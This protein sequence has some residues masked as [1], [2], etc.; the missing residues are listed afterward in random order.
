MDEY[1]GLLSVH[2]VGGSEGGVEQEAVV[3]Q[4]LGALD[5]GRP[6]HVLRRG[7]V[8]DCQQ[9]GQRL[10]HHVDVAWHCK[11]GGSCRPVHLVSDGQSYLTRISGIIYTKSGV[12]SLS[13]PLLA[14]TYVIE[15]EGRS[16]VVGGG[17][18][19]VS[20]GSIGHRSS[21]MPTVDDTENAGALSVMREWE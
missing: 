13:H 12:L 7:G 11:T 1:R 15:V 4:P 14:R 21:P 2:V 3:R 16:G 8:H 6:V 18:I 10:P 19:A 5:Q 17:L 9:L 20:C